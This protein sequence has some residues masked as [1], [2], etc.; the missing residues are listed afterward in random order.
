MFMMDWTTVIVTLIGSGG[1]V[2][3][4]LI[5]ERKTSASVENLRKQY[6]VLMDLFEKQQ[7]RHDK[8]VSQMAA[9]YEEKAALRD[10]LDA[11]NTRAAV[12]AIL[13]C[14]K[15]ACEHREP[16]LG[17]GVQSENETKDETE[18]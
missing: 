6:E 7:Q 13:R 5:T 2:G 17:Q 14:E 18:T 1:L 9:L 3:L 8:D 16:P 4:F 12:S 15:V 11:A 10:K